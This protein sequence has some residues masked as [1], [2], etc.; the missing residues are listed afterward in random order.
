[1]PNILPEHKKIINHNNRIFGNN[2]IAPK[3]IKFSIKTKDKSETKEYYID[4]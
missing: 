1:M 3:S 4:E 2:A